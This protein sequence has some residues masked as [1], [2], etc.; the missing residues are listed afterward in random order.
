M[1]TFSQPL[2]RN[3]STFTGTRQENHRM[4]FLNLTSVG[5]LQLFL[6]SILHS[7]RGIPR[8]FMFWALLV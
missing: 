6:A 7:P 1:V 3:V 4:Q 2:C 8:L 5:K